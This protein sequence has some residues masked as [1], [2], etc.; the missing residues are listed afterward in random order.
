MRLETS[1]Y[2]IAP[3]APRRNWFQIAGLEFIS[4]QLE[5]YLQAGDHNAR[6]VQLSGRFTKM[7]R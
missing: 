4:V 7:M 6:Y 5:L 1:I 3:G 2:L